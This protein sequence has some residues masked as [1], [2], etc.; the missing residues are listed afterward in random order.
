MALLLA[1]NTR[2]LVWLSDKAEK[3][4]QGKCWVQW[5]NSCLKHFQGRADAKARE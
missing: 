3:H 1:W 5:Q 4:V 2:R